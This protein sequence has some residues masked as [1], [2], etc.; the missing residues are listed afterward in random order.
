[1]SINSNLLHILAKEQLIPCLP[2]VRTEQLRSSGSDENFTISLLTLRLVFC[3]TLE[4]VGARRVQIFVMH[5]GEICDALMRL[6]PSSPQG[7]QLIKKIK[8]CLIEKLRVERQLLN[9]QNRTAF[10]LHKL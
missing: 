7:D 9:E 3:A 2:K 1:M 5:G 8:E 6:P 10:P 4:D